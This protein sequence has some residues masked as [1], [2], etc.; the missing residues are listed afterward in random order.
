MDRKKYT[1]NYIANS[2]K[3]NEL[4]NKENKKI[5][6]LYLIKYKKY[7]VQ[8]GFYDSLNLKDVKS[9]EE[10]QNYIQFIETIINNLTNES[11]EIIN[12]E[13]LSIDKDKNWWKG[14]YA[15]ST[16]FKMKQFAYKEFVLYVS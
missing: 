10:L 12:K 9:K 16:F 3:D 15:R 7:K 6:E 2:C 1:H 4:S 11:K 8:E 5:V 14:K 13:Y